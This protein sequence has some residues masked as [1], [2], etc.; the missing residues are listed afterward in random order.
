MLGEPHHYAYLV[1][2]IEAT[3]NRLAEQLRAGPFFLVEDVPLEGLVSGGEPAR[4]A[5]NSAFG[6]CGLSAI[7]LIETVELAPE[8]VEKGFSAPRPALHH[9][10]YVVAPDEVSGLRDTLEERGLPEYL[11]A[12]LGEVEMTFHDASA[13]LGHD[14]EIHVDNQQLRD[15]FALVRSAAEGWDGADPLRPFAP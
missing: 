6:A 14:L 8:R 7:E 11:S 5:H 4:F 2:D 9:F 10:A 12:R 13:A 3:A 15:S 1:E